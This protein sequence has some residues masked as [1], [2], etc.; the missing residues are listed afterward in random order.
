MSIGD[1]VAVP[2]KRKTIHMGE[3][4]GHYEFHPEA[5]NPYYHSR[6]VKWLEQDIPRTNFDQDI[7]NSLGA[8][9]TVCQIKRNDAEARVRAME[10]NEWKSAGI[11]AA[12]TKSDLEQ[13]ASDDEATGDL[14]L[15]QISRDHIAR[16]I[17]S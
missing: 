16:L 10:K 8:F 7:L 12:A 2:S 13:E 17:Y 9:T 3:I 4:T 1:W 5:E 15:E 6:S 11:K 14:D